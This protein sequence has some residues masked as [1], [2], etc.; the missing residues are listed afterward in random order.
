[1]LRGRPSLRRDGSR[2]SVSPQPA[3]PLDFRP[4]AGEQR[5]IIMDEII[6]I[7]WLAYHIWLAERASAHPMVQPLPLHAQMMGEAVDRPHVVHLVG[8]TML[9]VATDPVMLVADL[10][11]GPGQDLIASRRAKP[12]TAEGLGN[13]RIRGALGPQLPGA[14]HHGVVASDVALVQDRRDDDPLRD[15]ATDPDNLDRHPI[16]GH[17]LDN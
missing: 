4:Q 9:M 2:C 6:P 11:D 16:S 5:W 10:Q 8:S 13:L 12:C 17:A 15:M 3:T 7:G 14:F 1:M